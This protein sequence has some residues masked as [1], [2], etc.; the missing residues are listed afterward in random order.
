MLR[1]KIAR[2]LSI[3]IL[4]GTLLP[5]CGSPAREWPYFVEIGG[6]RI[7]VEVAVTPG[8]R[9]RG[10][11]DRERL[12]PDWGMLFVFQK[13]E[14]LKFWMHDT[15]VPLSIAFLGSDRVVRDVQ[16]M[17][18]MTD[19]EHLSSAPALYALEVNQGWFRRRG[20]GPGTTAKFSDGLEAYLRAHPATPNDAGE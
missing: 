20:V 15:K 1:W 6:A 14:T 9:G 13:E 11:M 16:D 5:G 7:N 18:P 10:L 4:L 19:D 3:S 2:I 8:E 12:R 17:S